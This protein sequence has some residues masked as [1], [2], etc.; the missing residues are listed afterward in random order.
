M[1][2]L[3]LRVEVDFAPAER[4]LALLERAP[5]RVRDLIA[6]RLADLLHE[7]VEFGLAEGFPARA[8]DGSYVCRVTG[9]LPGL[10]QRL[11]ASRARE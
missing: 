11:A 6:E 1:S 4:T 5:Q 3:I 9:A 10:E 7:H 8:A 2:E